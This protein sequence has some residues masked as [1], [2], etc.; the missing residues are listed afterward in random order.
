MGWARWS[1]C[2]A[3]GPSVR[4]VGGG[5]PPTDR[6][7]P[8]TATAGGSGV[9]IAAGA[10]TSRKTRPPTRGPH[11]PSSWPERPSPREQGAPGSAVQLGPKDC[12]TQTVLSP[13]ATSTSGATNS[14][15][16][17]SAGSAAARV[18]AGASV[19]FALSLRVVLIVP[20]SDGR[21]LARKLYHRSALDETAPAGAPP[22]GAV[23]LGLSYPRSCVSKTGCVQWPG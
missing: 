6:D 19:Q 23:V 21:R 2:S 11:G 8:S 7:K 20:S 13:S 14:G 9:A 22:A 18:G 17:A 3:G 10:S 5:C 12:L 16:S 1:V 15:R 4:S